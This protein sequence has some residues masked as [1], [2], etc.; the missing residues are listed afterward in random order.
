MVCRLEN[1]L[2][3]I[4]WPVLQKWRFI[5]EVARIIIQRLTTDTYKKQLLNAIKHIGGEKVFLRLI[6]K[7][8]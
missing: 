7:V 5:L 2:Y 8:Y 4:P 1:I 6:C 3:L